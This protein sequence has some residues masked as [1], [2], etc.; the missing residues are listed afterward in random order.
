MFTCRMQ[1]KL[2]SIS[3]QN[4]HLNKNDFLKLLISCR[5]CEHTVK[6]INT[7]HSYFHFDDT[8]LSVQ[9][10]TCFE[11]FES[12]VTLTLD[13][14]TFCRE[15]V[16][17][18][19]NTKNESLKFLEVHV[20][21][22]EM[23]KTIKDEYWRT[24][25]E[26]FPTLKVAFHFSTFPQF[27]SQIFNRNPLIHSD[28]INCLSRLNFVL[29]KDIPLTAIHLCFGETPTSKCY[30]EVLTLITKYYQHSLGNFCVN[31]AYLLARKMCCFRSHTIRHY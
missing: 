30:K 18:L 15:V 16:L 29:S 11:T 10:I 13:Y 14:S 12:L 4:A 31:N 20:R 8:L 19:I 7:H 5:S 1:T 21:D 23:N 26:K 25:K 24:L 6:Y 27:A 3:F 17:S 9:L 22:E 2:Q 28:Y